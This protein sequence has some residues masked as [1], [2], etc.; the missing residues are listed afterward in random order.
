VCKCNT[1][2]VC[3]C[4][5]ASCVFVVPVSLFACLFLRQPASQPV[6]LLVCALTLSRLRRMEDSRSGRGRKR[7]S[8]GL[9][10]EP[11]PKPS[12][13]SRRVDVDAEGAAAGDASTSREGK[14]G[15]HLQHAAGTSQAHSKR[16]RSPHAAIASAHASAAGVASRRAEEGKEVNSSRFPTDSDPN[17]GAR[18]ADSGAASGERGSG[19]ASGGGVTLLGWG[20]GGES[21]SGN[22]SAGSA[23]AGYLVGGGG[24]GGGRRASGGEC[25]SQASQVSHS[26]SSISNLPS[27]CSPHVSCHT[28]THTHTA[29]TAPP[30]DARSTYTSC[31][32]PRAYAGIQFTGF[33]VTNVLVLTPLE[34]RQAPNRSAHIQFTCFTGT[35]VLVLTPLELRQAPNRSAQTSCRSTD[36]Q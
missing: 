32:S 16:T 35:N 30:P 10:A 5:R 20:G 14:E 7:G 4:V 1:V 3:V 12:R 28:H 11:A 34:L 2:C 18:G 22:G 31:P 13:K 25:F 21:G 36:T 8:S 24:G 17:G 15:M 9:A 33:T 19:S 23:S 27:Q 29:P 26:N 6:S